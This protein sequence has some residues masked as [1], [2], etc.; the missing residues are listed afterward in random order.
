M[1]GHECLSINVIIANRV[2]Q[3]FSKDSEA[4]VENMIKNALAVLAAV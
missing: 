2:K 1:L 4:A 3:E